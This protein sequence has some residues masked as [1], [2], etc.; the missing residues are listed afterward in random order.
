MIIFRGLS[1]RKRLRGRTIGRNAGFVKWV[2][3]VIDG[4]REARAERWVEARH[5]PL[6]GKNE[7]LMDASVLANTDGRPSQ[8]PRHLEIIG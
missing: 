7:A 4:M 2:W 8:A 1:V 3:W 5:A 6:A